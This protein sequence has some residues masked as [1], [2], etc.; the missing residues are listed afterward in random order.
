M[1]SFNL[2][3]PP[4]DQF[5]HES[6]PIDSNSPRSWQSDTSIRYRRSIASLRYLIDQQPAELVEIAQ[7]Y[8]RA[9]TADI[10]QEYPGASSTDLDGTATDA[11][12][13]DLRA[14][15]RDSMITSY[16]TEIP[17]P[18]S[19]TSSE[20]STL[21]PSP[22][23]VARES[24]TTPSSSELQRSHRRSLSV[25]SHRQTLARAA[26][27]SNFFGTSRGAVWKVLLDDLSDVIQEETDLEDEERKAVLEGVARLRMSTGQY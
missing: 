4:A 25:G 26:K 20:F 13:A 2:T 17:T 3:T 10:V 7:E 22:P 5:A 6:D 23:A 14:F 8:S 21:P 19:S 16:A 27:L 1:P 15:L 11:G 12:T 24:R 18:T 9:S